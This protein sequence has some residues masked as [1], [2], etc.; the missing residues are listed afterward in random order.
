M[1]NSSQLYPSIALPIRCGKAKASGAQLKENWLSSLSYPLLS[2][3]TQQHQSDASNFKWV[4]GIDPDVSGAV[5]LLKTQHSHSD[6]AP[7]SHFEILH[8]SQLKGDAS[9][10]NTCSLQGIVRLPLG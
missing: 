9:W 4:L 1:Q 5:A 8:Q 10:W 3:D 7:Q 2:E 6:Y